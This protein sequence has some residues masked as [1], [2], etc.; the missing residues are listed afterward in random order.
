MGLGGSLW[1]LNMVG[2]KVCLMLTVARQNRV[3]SQHDHID[4]LT[5][6]L[7]SST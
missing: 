5:K 6:G 1:G 7:L 4:L 3:P 2:T